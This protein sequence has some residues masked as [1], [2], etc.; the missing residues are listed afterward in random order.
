MWGSGKSAGGVPL[1]VNILL[2]LGAL[3]SKRVLTTTRGVRPRWAE[4]TSYLGPQTRPR[5]NVVYSHNLEGLMGRS[6]KCFRNI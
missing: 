4:H 1:A 3:G 5:R 2:P 6:G